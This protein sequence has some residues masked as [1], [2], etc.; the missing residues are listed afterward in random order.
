MLELANGQVVYVVHAARCTGVG[1][2]GGCGIW[3]CGRTTRVAETTFCCEI[4]C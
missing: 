3:G 4:P 2:R 1:K